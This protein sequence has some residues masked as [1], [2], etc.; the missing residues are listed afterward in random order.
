MTHDSFLALGVAAAV[1]V[2]VAAA[3]G[4]LVGYRV[5]ATRP[6]RLLRR[7]R[8]DTQ[9]CLTEAASAIDLAG[10]FCD[11]V[12]NAA[13]IAE[14]RIAPLVERQRR[15]SDSISRL[16]SSGKSAARH[17]I[18][19]VSWQREPLEAETQLPDRTGFEANV[20]KIAAPDAPRGGV[21]LVSLD[22]LDRLRGRIGASGLS[23]VRRTV[24]RVLCRAG[25]EQDLACVLDGNGFAVLLPDVDPEEA[26]RQAAGIRDVFRGHPFRLGIDG[27][28][29][30]VTASYGFTPVLPGDESRLV[31]DR[32]EAAVARAR[33]WGRSRFYAYDPAASR[34]VQ[35]PDAAKPRRVALTSA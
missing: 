19:E 12:A 4:F 25:R 14:P 2:A 27:P 35:V 7:A 13:K 21:L 18:A 32:V 8:R 17:D 24:A 30:L 10:R 29:V 22:G 3:G 23:E 34:L 33:R 9:R 28:E 20:T 5:A 11:A 1:G 31:L 16:L 26:L 15:L 6:A